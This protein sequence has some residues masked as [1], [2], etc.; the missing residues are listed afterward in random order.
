LQTVRFEIP[1]GQGTQT[2]E[3]PADNIE[4]VLLSSDCPRLKTENEIIS[5]AIQNPID[6]PRLCE[7]C[8]RISSV[9]LITN[10]MTRPMPSRMTLPAI[11]CEIKTGNPAAHITIIIASGLHRAMTRAELV[12]KMGAEIVDTY[13]IIVHDAYDETSLISLGYLSTSNQLWIN[14]AI[15]DHE[16]II[17]EGF[18]E[19][20]WLAGYSGG[21]K[22]ILPG[23]AGARTVMHNHGPANVEHAS[24]KP[25]SLTDN[26]AHQEQLEAA[27]KAGLKFIFNVVLDRNKHISAAFAGSPVAA[28]TMGCRHVEKIMGV[29]CRRADIVISSNNGYPLDINLYQSMKGLVTAAAAAK[30][31]GVLILSSECIEGVGQ[32]GFIQVY[33]K[34]T[35]PADV[36]DKLRSGTISVFDQWSSQVWLRLA[37]KY[38]VI[39][40]SRNI[41]DAVA[42]KMAIHRTDTVA[43][44]L[45]LAL[46]I[47]GPSAR[48]NV[49]PEGPVIIPL[50]KD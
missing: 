40:A 5:E 49:I 46:Q 36:L 19:A 20:H 21:R 27:Q 30:N 22:S 42:A 43:Q 4:G 8:R 50:V 31:G 3:I 37:L 10:D 16:L 25:G 47:K 34:G 13:P 9:L 33:D 32:E 48:I 12:A 23:I 1:H 15:N 28:H 7:L 6:S 18:I 38:T 17:S 39:V 2:V 24:V 14:R 45:A 41:S 29:P 35:D 44:A 26:P 11:I